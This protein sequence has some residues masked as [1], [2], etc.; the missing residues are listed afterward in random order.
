MTTH[1]GGLALVGGKHVEMLSS[2]F[3]VAAGERLV[4]AL[5]LA[6]DCMTAWTAYIQELRER[7]ISAGLLPVQSGSVD[8]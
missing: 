4:D 2:T 5:V 8:A 6:E 1:E 7:A 3:T